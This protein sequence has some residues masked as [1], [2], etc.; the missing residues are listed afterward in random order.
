[1]FSVTVVPL[2][3]GYALPVVGSVPVRGLAHWF[4]NSDDG[5]NTPAW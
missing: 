4:A 5:A 3:S 1:M 2:T